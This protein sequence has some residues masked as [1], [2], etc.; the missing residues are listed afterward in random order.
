M[1]RLLQQRSSERPSLREWAG[2]TGRPHADLP[3]GPTSPDQAAQQASQVHGH[4]IDFQAAKS[5]MP[6]TSL[7]R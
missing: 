4:V 1:A 3:L 2:R 7:A 5:M 6:V